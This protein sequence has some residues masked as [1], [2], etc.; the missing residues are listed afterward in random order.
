LEPHSREGK[1]GLAGIPVGVAITILAPYFHLSFSSA[2]LVSIIVFIPSILL[3]FWQSIKKIRHYLQSPIKRPHKGEELHE[4]PTIQ[5]PA[6]DV[7]SKR[8]L[9]KTADLISKA[10]N[11]IYFLGLTLESLRQL[12]PS[13]ENALR[14]NRRIRVLLLDSKSTLKERV[15]RVVVTSDIDE[16]IDRTVK[17]LGLSDAKPAVTKEQKDNL[18]TRVH[19]EIP[20][21]SM[22]IVDPHLE[23][24][25]YMQIEPYPYG[26]T[27]GSRNVLR[28]TGNGIKQQE[29][30]SVF[31][32]GYNN[33]WERA[34]K[35][36]NI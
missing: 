15:E 20:F 1:I 2:L 31:L 6:L 21:S 23:P 22:I 19:D 14:K 35:P 28:L 34:R 33:L 29:A 13:I 5:E 10:S 11:E 16:G 4:P 32:D 8:E 30:F 7:C 12:I 27:S 36:N 18:E 24:T 26:I 9:P 3:I 25:R 17:S